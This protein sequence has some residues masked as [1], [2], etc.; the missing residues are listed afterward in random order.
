MTGSGIRV[1]VLTSLFPSHPGEKQGNFVLDQ[2]RE[3][4]AQGADV[5][6]LVAK[7][8][9]PSLLRS[10]ASSDKRKI[11]LSVYAGEPFRIANASYFSLPR[12]ALGQYAA[13]FMESLVPAIE[14]LDVQANFDIIHAHGLPLGHVAVEAAARLRSPSVLTIHGI[15][16]AARFDN[17][18][19]KR[20]QLGDTLDR[21]TAVVLVGSPLLDYVRKYTKKTDHCTVIGNGFVSYPGLEPSQLVPRSRPVRVVAVSNYEPSKGFE[22]LV[23]AIA[24]L[25]PEVREKIETILVGGGTGFESVRQ[26]VEKLGLTDFVHYTGPLQHRDAMA[27]ILAGDVF[28][29]P[30]SREAFGIMY[31]EAMSLGKLTIGCRG[32]GPSDFIRDGETG[33]LIEPQSAMAVADALRWVVANPDRAVQVAD[34]GRTYALG[35]LTWAHNAEKIIGLYRNLLTKQVKAG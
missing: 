30:S 16:T 22:L 29:L 18:E 10:Y 8:W 7:P 5:T 25:E 28:C 34:S 3:L 11:D 13:R 27:E 4:A 26:L 33:L 9:I 24:S 32:Q 14:Y 17:T 31:A 6:V 1:L 19:S 21:I 12:F 20:A 2:V 23:E 15:E 35:Q